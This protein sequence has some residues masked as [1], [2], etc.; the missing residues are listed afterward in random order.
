MVALQSGLFNEV[1][2]G[3]LDTLVEENEEG[4]ECENHFQVTIAEDPLG[5]VEDCDDQLI[6]LLHHES[7]LLPQRNLGKEIEEQS[8]LVGGGVPGNGFL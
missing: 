8:G 7:V 2:E 5:S 3:G 1:G 6:Q 4:L